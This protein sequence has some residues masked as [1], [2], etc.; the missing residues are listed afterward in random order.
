MMIFLFLAI[1]GICA[2]TFFAI[3][4]ARK[5]KKEETKPTTAK[6]ANNVPQQ[7]PT[8]GQNPENE[9]KPDAG[10]QDENQSANQQ[11]ETDQQSADE[12][13]QQSEHEEQSQE[14]LDREEVY[15]AN[16]YYYIEKFGKNIKRDG[17]TF[18]YLL[19]LFREAYAQYYRQ[20]SAHGLPVLYLEENFPKIY[21]FYGHKGNKDA[22]FRTLIGWL[23]ALQLAEL[24]PQDRTEIFKTGYE[25]GGYTKDSDI[26]GYQW[27]CDPNDCREV[28]AAIYA[29]M[30]GHLKPDT[31]AMQQ[32]IGWQDFDMSIGD[33]RDEDSFKV[34]QYDFFTDLRAFLPTAPGPYA[35]GYQDRSQIGGVP[36]PTEPK[37]DDNNLCVDRS[38]YETVINLFNLDTESEVC[39]QM[40]VQAIANKDAHVEHLFGTTRHTE[41]YSFL[42]AFTEKTLGQT[43]YPSLAVGLCNFIDDVENI[44]SS[45]RCIM[46][47]HERQMTPYQYGRL[48]PGCS[49]QMEAH[50]HSDTDVT[51]NVLVCFDIEEHDGHPTGYYNEDGEWDKKSDIHSPEEY[52]DKMQDELWANS[53]PSGHSAAIRGASLALME[54]LPMQADKLLRASNWYALHRSVARFHWLSDTRIGR[55]LAACAYAVLHNCCDFDERQQEARE[56]LN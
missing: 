30:R 8:D 19:E 23:F 7:K 31:Q 28:A 56:C 53:Y 6:P 45:Q 36:Y 38:V 39:R 40:T 16:T 52:N 14:W 9:Q 29:M 33:V 49:W 2:G 12:P 18:N 20:E 47:G 17:I 50:R 54:L 25:Y 41:D 27:L 5:K 43:I 22:A 13:G 4:N 3:R 51:Q 1:I 55:V 34:G 48:R 44:C 26:Y 21:D 24:L 35:P 32:E 11:S 42:P 37:E 46:Q 15:K 10:Q